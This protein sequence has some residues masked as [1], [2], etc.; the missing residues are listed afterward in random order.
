MRGGARCGHRYGTIHERDVR[1][2]VTFVLLDLVVFI[3]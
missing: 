1:G 2:W 3:L